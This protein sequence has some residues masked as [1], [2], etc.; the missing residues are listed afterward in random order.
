MKPIKI[1]TENSAAIHDALRAVNGK[2]ETH[3]YKYWT[4]IVDLSAYAEK[5]LANLGIPK[6]ERAGAIYSAISGGQLPNAYKYTAIGTAVEITRRSSAWYLTKV[7][8]ADIYSGNR[9]KTDWLQVTAKQD[10]KA[11]EVLRR[12]YT[13][14]GQPGSVEFSREQEAKY[15]QARADQEA[16]QAAYA[17]RCRQI[18]AMAD[19]SRTDLES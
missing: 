8:R 17:E 6:A 11:V 2:A 16:E 15:A 1:V 10:A 9:G 18:A 4:Q 5:C 13:I 7:E 19:I 12:G 3:T 14:A